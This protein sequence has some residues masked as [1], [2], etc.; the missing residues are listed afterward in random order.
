MWEWGT[1]QINQ[2][3]YLKCTY[4]LKLPHKQ[5]PVS[6]SYF[7]AVPISTYS[8]FPPLLLS[9]VL[10][11]RRLTHSHLPAT[12][13]V[14]M[15]SMFLS[16]VL[17][18]FLS[19]RLALSTALSTWLHAYPIDPPTQHVW[20]HVPI[21]FV[22]KYLLLHLYFLSEFISPTFACLQSYNQS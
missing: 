7:P 3:I 20:T 9:N 5:W 22:P 2:K 14:L 19:S 1:S 18:S 8:W 17:T 16:P 10:L 6:H 15:A 4:A 13:R 21:L 12:A 11:L